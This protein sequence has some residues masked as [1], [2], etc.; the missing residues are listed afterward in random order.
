LA[1][2]LR[3]G[4]LI[5]GGEYVFRVPGL[6][7][8]NGDTFAH[9]TNGLPFALIRET[10]FD[11]GGNNT[12]KDWGESM[13][14]WEEMSGA[15]GKRPKEAYGIRETRMQLCADAQYASRLYYASIP[16]WW[17]EYPGNAFP[18]V[19]LLLQNVHLKVELHHLSR[20]YVSGPLG[21]KPFT[22]TGTKGH[23]E[24]LNDTSIDAYL[25]LNFVLLDEGERDRMVDKSHQYLMHQVQRHEQSFGCG[26]SNLTAHKISLPFAH[27]VYWMCWTAQQ[28]D[29]ILRKEWFNY[30]GIGGH[31]PII[32]ARLSINGGDRFTEREAR[33]FRLISPMSQGLN[34]P[35]RHIYSF[36]FG[37]RANIFQP[38]GAQ[39]F[40]RADDPALYLRLQPCLS[41]V[42]VVVYVR[43]RNWFRL[44]GG[45]GGQVFNG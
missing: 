37:I 39:N 45:M 5:Y 8:V 6:V 29:A 19:A 10:Q 20:L 44:I 27:P 14:I 12:A 9:W 7:P 25:Y 34:V 30:E 21:H 35:T 18:L 15:A 36:G 1:Q 2:F 23:Y 43:N 42:L 41:E 11:V 32:S 31:D 40:S 17:G 16:F 38:T 13:F 26:Q 22:V 33:Y 28:H 24:A 3:Y 4:D